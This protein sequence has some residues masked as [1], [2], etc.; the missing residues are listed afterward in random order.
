MKIHIELD[1]EAGLDLVE[2]EQI[3]N[4]EENRLLLSD[5]YR[6]LDRDPKLFISSYGIV[7][8]SKHLQGIRNQEVVLE[9]PLEATITFEG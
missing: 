8:Q 5:L 1:I 9:L 6:L 4:N 3:F 7:D 2:L